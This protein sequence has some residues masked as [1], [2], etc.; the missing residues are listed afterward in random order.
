LRSPWEQ[1]SSRNAALI[2]VDNDLGCTL[3][4][5]ARRRSFFVEEPKCHT[6]RN[7]RRDE[8]EEGMKKRVWYSLYGTTPSAYFRTRRKELTGLHDK[9][10]KGWLQKFGGDFSVVQR[11]GAISN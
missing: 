11:F 3:S 10:V 6:S 1:E 8:A 9:E 7:G 5:T 2:G 4:E